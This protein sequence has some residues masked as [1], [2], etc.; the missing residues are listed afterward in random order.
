M[1]YY[2]DMFGKFLN[3]GV[4]TLLLLVSGPIAAQE[5]DAEWD[6]WEKALAEEAEEAS[7]FNDAPLT[8]EVKTPDWFQLTFLDLADDLADAERSGRKGLIVY[9]GQKYCPY[10]RALMEDLKQPDIRR[11]TQFH[12]DV[13]EVNIHGDRIV[14]DLEGNELGEKAFAER[15]NA[16]LTPT[17]I[18]YDFAGRQAHKL[19]GYHS[20][21]RFR[22]ALEYVAGDHYQTESFRSYLK[23]AD[24]NLAP[25]EGE[26]NQSE[27]FASPPFHL[28]RTRFPGE[29]PLIVFFEQADCHACDVLHSGPMQRRAISDLL[30]QFDTVQLGLWDETPVVT[31]DG[32][33]LT[34]REWSEKLQLFY[35]PTLLFFDRDGEEILRLDSVAH[36]YRIQGVLQYI[37]SDAHQEGVA[38]QEW[39]RRN[40]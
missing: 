7:E 1:V 10:C 14:T 9:F 21:Y 4:L 30:D 11:Y 39:S 33:R 26:L 13:V 24:P 22:A 12:F 32:E 6:A 3:Q 19:T 34:A 27:S 15:E 37:L 23:R 25:R 18:F 35:A 31:P 29:R 36:F 38:L 40:R 20:A 5:P 17:L 2:P 16:N 8:E 28:D